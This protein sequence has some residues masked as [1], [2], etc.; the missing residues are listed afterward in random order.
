MSTTV[1]HAAGVLDC[2]RNLNGF[3]IVPRVYEFKAESICLDQGMSTGLEV[4]KR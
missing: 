2:A 3:S 1:S 4:R